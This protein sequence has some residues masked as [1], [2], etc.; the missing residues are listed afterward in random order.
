[1]W[2]TQ[3][4][5]THS[6]LA[7]NHG[8]ISSLN[9]HRLLIPGQ[10]LHPLL[11]QLIRIDKQPPTIIITQHLILPIRLQSHRPCPI[12]TSILEPR[13]RRSPTNPRIQP[14]LSPA[15]NFHRALS[16]L[17]LDFLTRKISTSTE[18]KILSST[19][20]PTLDFCNPRAIEKATIA[21]VGTTGKDEQG[22]GGLPGFGEEGVGGDGGDGVVGG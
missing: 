14:Q 22:G 3:H 13:K 8:H 21:E 1:M 6:I 18:P 5:S 15:H 12:F 4:G 7:I 11:S 10:N 19:Q 2:T 17:K 9:L 16:N 20:H